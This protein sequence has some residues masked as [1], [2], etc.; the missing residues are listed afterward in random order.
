MIWCPFGDT[1]SAQDVACILVD[2]KLVAC[3]NIIPDIT[4]VYR[5]KGEVHKDS[6]VG[7]LFKTTDRLL[8][9]AVKRL[10][11]L[12]PYDTPAISGWHVDH[13]P[14]AT[15]EWL[16]HQIRSEGRNGR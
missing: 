15:L 3:A 8:E 6:E 10:A 13:A 1:N 5:W 14:P 4:S 7:V 9:S 16:E 12:H 11:E 2:E